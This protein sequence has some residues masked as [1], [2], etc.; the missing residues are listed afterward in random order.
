MTNSSASIEELHKLDDQRKTLLQET[1]A[2]QPQSQVNGEAAAVVLNEVPETNGKAESSENSEDETPRALRRGLDRK[3]KREEDAARKRKAKKEKAAAPKLSKAEMKL[4][5]TIEEVEEKKSEILECEESIGDITNELRETD[6]QRTRCLGRDRF[7]NR[8]VWFERNGMPFAGVPDTST[9][10]YNYANGRLWVQGPD[11]MDRSGLIDRV[12]DEQ[13]HYKEAFNMTVVERKELEEGP[14]HLE[15]ATQWAYIDDPAAVDQ[16]MAW[17]DER[18][19][20]EKAL[21]KELGLWRDM[22]VDCM[23]KMRE[24]ID[25]TEARKTAAEEP[26]AGMRISTRTKN[27]GDLDAAKWQCL[28]WRNTIAANQLGMLHSDGVKKARKKGV[29]EAKVKVPLGKNGKPLTR[30][31]K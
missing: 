27:H 10:H 8:Y 30:Q 21:R 11:E 25:E 6:C 12:S 17:L 28:A 9:A 22:I 29:A 24:H 1:T 14:T 7:C 15:N 18:G 31:G 26:Q 23:K 3:R 5:K 20:R 4:R 16:L 19:N 2:T 13:T